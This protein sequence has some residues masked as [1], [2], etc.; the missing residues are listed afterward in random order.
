MVRVFRVFVPTSVLALLISEFILI[1]SCYMAGGFFILERGPAVYLVDEGG[2]WRIAAVVGCV[3]V[4][5]YFHDLYT[6]FR[7]RSRIVLFQQV[8]LVVGIAFLT[9]ALFTYIK[10]PEWALPKWL[11]IYGSGL[12][13]VLLPVWRI[14]YASFVMKAIGSERLLFLGSSPVVQQIGEYLAEHPEVGLSA[15]R[16]VDDCQTADAD[17]QR[18]PT[19]ACMTDLA[20]TMQP[21]HPHR[22]I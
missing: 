2:L 11:M 14:I 17:V 19:I 16:D 3:M 9:Q 21:P 18:I 1:F 10:R 4:G 8:C 6:Q 22:I 12:V 13:L 20:A 7:I 15:I 5:I